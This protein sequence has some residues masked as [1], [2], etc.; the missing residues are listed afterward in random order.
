MA[1]A[2]AQPQRTTLI[3]RV[4]TRRFS[5]SVALVAT[6]VLLV[7]ALAQLSIA[8][9]FSP[10]PITGQTL[11]VMVIG[12]AY[13]ANL[14]ALTLASYAIVGLIGVPVFADFSGG[15]HT[16]ASP[17]FGY[18][19]GFIAAAYVV[20]LLSERQWDRSPLRAIAAF[21]LASA[22]PFLIGVPYLAGAL[23]ASG[24]PTSL[25]DAI[26]FGFVPFIVPG[27]VKWAIAAAALP[28]AHR[29][30]TAVRRGR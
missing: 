3:D 11:G 19:I 22:I 25:G 15:I 16:V 27:L 6:G 13:G 12:A 17:T 29:L 20:G 5:V 21:G 28:A 26:A 14:G 24:V 1:I 8:V 23:T 7:G 9:P 10:V 30:V 18:I 2:V 4:V